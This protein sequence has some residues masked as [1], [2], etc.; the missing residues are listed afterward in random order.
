[1]TLPVL[2]GNII[3]NGYKGRGK[4]RLSNG[5]IVALRVSLQDEDK[6]VP[7]C[8]DAVRCLLFDSP[9]LGMVVVDWAVE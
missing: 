9:E 3:D 4:V 6:R 8:G 1:V 2:K 7:K 5:K